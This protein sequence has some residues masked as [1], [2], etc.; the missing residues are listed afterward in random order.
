MSRWLSE[1]GFI[2]EQGSS[3]NTDVAEL[4]QKEDGKATLHIEWWEERKN[5]RI[6][7]LAE[8]SGN[9][10]NFIGTVLAENGALTID[11]INW[12]KNG[13]FDKGLCQFNSQYR[14]HILQ[15]KRFTDWKWQAN[16]CLELYRGWT[17]FYW[18]NNRHKFTRLLTLK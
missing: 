5:E 16:K 17:T 10:K 18:Y 3:K 11:A 4:Q 12:N 9:D 1:V 6:I 13:T 7:Y 2:E 15:D 8:I 14:Q